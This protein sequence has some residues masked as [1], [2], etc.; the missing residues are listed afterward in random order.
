[1]NTVTG[2]PRRNFEILLIRPSHY[3]DDG[4]VIQWWRS[5]MPS[6]SLATM[7][8]LATD[9][10]D[11]RVLGPDVDIHVTTIDEANTRIKPAALIERIKTAGAGGFLG[12]VGLQSNQYPRAL[13][14]ARPFRDAGIPAVLGTC[15][16]ASVSC[17]WC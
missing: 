1:M 10:A 7:N 16:L 12:L 14:I 11:R 5:L 8:G 4:Y 17:V 2:S 6:N 13:D 15:A 3:D 9:A